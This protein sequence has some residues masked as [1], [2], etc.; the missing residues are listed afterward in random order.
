MWALCIRSKI[1]PVTSVQGLGCAKTPAPAAHVETSQRNCA[2]N[3]APRTMFDTLLENCIFYVSQLYEFSH[4]LGHSRHSRHPGLS[5]SPQERPLRA[6]S[7]QIAFG[8]LEIIA[9]GRIAIAHLGPRDVA[10]GRWSL[11]VEVVGATRR[12]MLPRI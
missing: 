9:D 3:R 1:F 11:A 10:D 8:F 7:G 4:R 2:P 5:G 12:P 6:A